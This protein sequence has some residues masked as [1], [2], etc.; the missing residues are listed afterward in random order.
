MSSQGV[1][2]SPVQTPAGL[3]DAFVLIYK[4]LAILI[5]LTLGVMFL[6][7]VIDIFLFQ[8]NEVQQTV[9]LVLNKNL[10][11]KDTTDNVAMDY[12]K[13]NPEDEPYNIFLEQKMIGGLFS[14]SGIGLIVLGLQIGT[15]F[16]LKLWSVVKRAE[17]AE[18]INLPLKLIMV[19][20]VGFGAATLFTSNYNQIFVKQTQPNIKSIRTQM[21]RLNNYIYT[22]L[23]N[24]MRNRF[25]PALLA[26]DLDTCVKV[27]REYLK[28]GNEND[29]ELTAEDYT[30]LKMLF[31]IN[32]YGFYR[33]MIPEGDPVFDELRALFTTQGIRKRAI[34][35]TNYIYY[36]HAVFV[37]NAYPTIRDRLQPLLGMR[38]R[39]FVTELGKM[40]RELNRQMVYL[41]DIS[42]GKKALFNYL[43]ATFAVALIWIVIIFGVFYQ[44]LSPFI[45][46]VVQSLGSVW[47]KLRGLLQRFLFMGTGI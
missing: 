38:E 2:P 11:N 35:P 14:L 5:A 40:M 1:Y 22:N 3:N 27:L 30:A 43:L 24:D 10:F 37:P 4:I 25:L 17:F 13:N 8:R 31:T 39:T 6:T 28:R 33:Y 46:V 18:Q 42:G 26:D 41:K 47:E 20:V 29:T 15:F 34:E 44:E 21:L 23:T 32:I 36:K 45:G 16:S 9:K 7:T 12:L 19:L